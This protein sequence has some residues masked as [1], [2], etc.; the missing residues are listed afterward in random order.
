METAMK[1]IYGRKETEQWHASRNLGNGIGVI[2][3]GR[4]KLGQKGGK[5]ED[6]TCGL[7]FPSGFEYSDILTQNGGFWHPKLF[8]K[9]PNVGNAN[10]GAEKD[11]QWPTVPHNVILKREYSHE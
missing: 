9:F 2:A 7:S 6:Q 11:I 4:P 1:W 3:F 8:M 10:F 5:T